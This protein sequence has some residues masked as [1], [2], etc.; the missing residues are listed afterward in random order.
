MRKPFLIGYKRHNPP[1]FKIVNFS[2]F[3]FILH[4]KYPNNL[5]Q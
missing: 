3:L 5:F 2:I 1:G 4:Y